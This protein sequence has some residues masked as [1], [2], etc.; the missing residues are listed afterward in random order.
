VAL[1]EVGEAS[2][3]FSLRFATY[4]TLISWG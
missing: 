2:S 3:A 4:L 1:P